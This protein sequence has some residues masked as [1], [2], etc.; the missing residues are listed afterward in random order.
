MVRM[1]WMITAFVGR[2]GLYPTLPCL[3]RVVELPSCWLRQ[4]A[5]AL[6]FHRLRDEDIAFHCVP[7]TRAD[8]GLCLR[9]KVHSVF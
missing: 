5:F 3:C 1:I 9:A 2:V 4:V 6:C 8:A 7:H